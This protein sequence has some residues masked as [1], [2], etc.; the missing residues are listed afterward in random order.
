MC[1]TKGRFSV[2]FKMACWLIAIISERLCKYLTTHNNIQHYVDLKLP[3]LG[4]SF[5]RR[6][7]KAKKGEQQRRFSGFLIRDIFA[8][9]WIIFF[10]TR[11]GL[12]HF[13]T[14]QLL[15]K[16]INISF[17]FSARTSSCKEAKL[18]LFG[19]QFNFS[20]TERSVAKSASID[21]LVHSTVTQ[22]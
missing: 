15:L 5:S 6:H 11:N 14:C 12:Y 2:L 9:I 20:L 16:R 1:E 13:S 8:S 7:H 4:L 17:I 18:V 10:N 19:K 22:G 21:S 3:Y